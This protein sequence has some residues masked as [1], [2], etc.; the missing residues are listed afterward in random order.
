MRMNRHLSK[1]TGTAP[2]AGR[3]HGCALAVAVLLAASV[4]ASIS[5]EASAAVRGKKASSSVSPVKKEA[6]RLYKEGQ[7]QFERGDYA[8]ASS[9]WDQA[10]SMLPS[11]EWKLRGALLYN[12]A[13]A[14]EKVFAQTGNVKRLQFAR[15]GLSYYLDELNR[16]QKASKDKELAAIEKKIQEK[17]ASLDARVEETKRKEWASRP[18]VPPHLASSYPRS[19]SMRRAVYREILAES[20]SYASGKQ[21]V[22]G[23]GVMLGFGA[24][25]ATLV[26]LPV[27]LVG[28]PTIGWPVFGIGAGLAVGG[29]ILLG[30]GVRRSR[31]AKWDAREK[32]GLAVLPVLD[33]GTGAYG[34]GLRG[35]F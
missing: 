26:G 23:G 12:I 34:V 31:E 25:S 32:A 20:P 33:V 16:S 1:T 8:L 29:G 22:V 13:L 5:T 6:L 11:N 3:T 30:A 28:I 4:C 14:E 19:R 27:A 9:Q 10:Y 21:M 17:I 24:A 18:G 2:N 35:A 15:I 7:K